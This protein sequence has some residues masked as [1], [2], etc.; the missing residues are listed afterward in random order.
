MNLNIEIEFCTNCHMHS[1]CSQHD[2]N[3]YEFHFEKIKSLIL[4]DLE[5][6]EHVTI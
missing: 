1:W 4:N 3:K 2:E 6:D 5:E